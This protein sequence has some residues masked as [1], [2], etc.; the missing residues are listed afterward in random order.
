VLILAIIFFLPGGI[1]GF[2]QEKLKEKRE[3]KKQRGE[4]HEFPED[5]GDIKS[6]R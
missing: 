3:Y 2:L 5:A 1:L 6:I 4:S